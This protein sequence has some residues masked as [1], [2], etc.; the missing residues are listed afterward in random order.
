MRSN[1]KFDI[2]DYIKYHHQFISLTIRHSVLV[3]ETIFFLVYTKSWDENYQIYWFLSSLKIKFHAV[4]LKLLMMIMRECSLF[5]ATFTCHLL[6][7]SKFQCGVRFRHRDSSTAGET[8]WKR[9]I[10]KTESTSFQ[11]LV[12]YLV[13]TQIRFKVRLIRWWA[14]LILMCRFRFQKTITT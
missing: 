12:S 13:H 1:V 4:N 14:S 7:N 9:F 8:N 3:W 2:I 11:R 5:T 6:I 10:L